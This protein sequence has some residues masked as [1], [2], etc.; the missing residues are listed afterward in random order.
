MEA[1]WFAEKFKDAMEWGRR[2]YPSQEF[3]VVTG[4]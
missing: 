3:Y 2:F 1:K 4:V